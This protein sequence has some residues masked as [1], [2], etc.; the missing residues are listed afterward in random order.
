[1]VV[2]APSKHHWRCIG[3]SI[4]LQDVEVA[5]VSRGTG[6]EVEPY[7][8]DMRSKFGGIF[9][10]ETLGLA[11]TRNLYDFL[12][13]LSDKGMGVQVFHA[14]SV[15][16]GNIGLAQNGQTRKRRAW[17]RLPSPSGLSSNGSHITSPLIGLPG[18][19]R[20][21]GQDIKKAIDRP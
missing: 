1:M 7:G 6:A 9:I 12:P 19:G 8:V 16:P 17:L 18:P 21:A 13:F 20:R 5:D 14:F 2:V 11:D 15:V 10:G 4:A 3:E